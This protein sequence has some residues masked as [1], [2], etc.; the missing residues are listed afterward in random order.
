[1]NYTAPKIVSFST[2]EAT[3]RE[4]TRK[5][6]HQY[7][8]VCV[9]LLRWSPDD[10]TAALNRAFAR[11][12]EVLG[13]FA[14]DMKT[15]FPTGLHVLVRHADENEG[16]DCT[17]GLHFNVTSAEKLAREAPSAVTVSGP[18]QAGPG[19][20]AVTFIEG[21]VAFVEHTTRTPHS[22]G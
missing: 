18:C 13:R 7:V 10:D 20:V 16:V 21:E 4:K 22:A 2:T 15:G 9:P 1:M 19:T 12:D 5:Y 3:W 8:V 11:V 14:A 6:D 17:L